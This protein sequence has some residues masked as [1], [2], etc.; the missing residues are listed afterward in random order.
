[1]SL[2]MLVL[3]C[4]TACAMPPLRL[5]RN[6]VLVSYDVLLKTQK[7]I[8]AASCSLYFCIQRELSGGKD[9]VDNQLEWA[10]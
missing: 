3:F 1:M 10:R 2:L 9:G 4:S 8:L 6:Q 7:C 5:A